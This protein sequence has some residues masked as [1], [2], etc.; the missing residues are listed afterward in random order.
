MT[1]PREVRPGTPAPSER[2]CAR[3]GDVVDFEGQRVA[4]GPCV[5]R[6]GRPVAHTAYVWPARRN[7]TL[8]LSMAGTLALVSAMVVLFFAAAPARP[9]G[10]RLALRTVLAPGPN[11]AP[12]SLA[13]TDCVQ[14]HQPSDNVEDARCERCHDPALSARLSNAA[15]AFATS[16]D[17]SLAMASPTMACATCHVEHLGAEVDLKNVDDRECGT[18]HRSTPE[19]GPRLTSLDNHPE[20]AVVRAGVELSGG[21][22]WFNHALHLDKVQKKFQ[23]GCETCHEREGKSPAFQPIVFARHCATCHDAD[24]AQSAGSLTPAMIAALGPLRPGLSVQEDPDDPNLKTLTGFRHADPW[25]LRS[26]QSLR[27]GIDPTGF[28]AERLALDRQVAQIELTTTFSPAQSSRAAWLDA[29]HAGRVSASGDAALPAVPVENALRDLAAA[30]EAMAGTFGAESAALAAEAARLKNAAGNPKAGPSRGSGT[31]ALRQLIEATIV[32]ARAAGDAG[33]EARAQGLLQRLDKVPKADRTPAVADAS[34]AGLEILLNEVS[35]IRDPASR[36]EV[37]EMFDLLRLSRRKAA[38]AMD[39]T[40]FDRHRQQ[41]LV[42]LDSV[43]SSLLSQAPGAADPRVSALLARE[44]SLRR[45]VLATP[46]SLAPEAAN[47]LARFFRTREADR[48]RIDLELEQA[49]LRVTPPRETSATPADAEDRL[50]KLRARLAALASARPLGAPLAA[51]DARLAVAALLGTAATDPESNVLR[52][53]RCTMCHDLTAEGDQLAPLR[54]VGES[55]MP[56]ARFTHEKHVSGG[57]ENCETCHTN[58][59][60]SSLAAEVNLPDIASCRTCH[61]PGR[62]AAR[63]SGCES[64]HTYHVPSARALRWRP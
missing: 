14:C 63:V 25:F 54:A 2:D 51:A 9:G 55:L 7:K 39:P 62:Q 17:V 27:Q 22:K 48:T 13:T 19:R 18:C 15:H 36:E 29:S 64:C 59:R 16:G 43:R 52:K 1:T 47:A 32:R 5:D 49:A 23:K 20:F 3:E 44:N 42:L 4:T 33:M 12:H 46:Y 45:L 8:L 61:A 21:L 28:A 60:K 41:I 30:V 35:K 56:S 37:D 10:P 40:A 26:V 53:N 31:E 11:S 50:P 6:E 34:S 24:L 57:A 38:G 58:I